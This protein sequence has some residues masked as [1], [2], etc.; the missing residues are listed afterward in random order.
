M[1]NDILF[2]KSGSTTGKSALVETDEDFGIWSPLAIIRANNKIIHK[3]LF[4]FIQS[5]IFRTQV[6][7]FWSFGT[8]PNIGMGTLENLFIAYSKDLQ[9]QQLIVDFLD[10]KTA[11]I[12]NTIEKIK[13][14]IEKLKEAKQSLISEAVT[15]KIE[16]M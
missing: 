10:E 4:Y 2:C 6:E 1:K 16:V 9:E 8:Q 13:V 12:D 11:K 15:G 14:Q 5:R 3:G 7:V